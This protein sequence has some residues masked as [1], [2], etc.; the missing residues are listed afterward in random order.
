MFTDRSSRNGSAPRTEAYISAQVHLTKK[1]GAGNRWTYV[2]R[3]GAAVAAEKSVV[4]FPTFDVPRVDNLQLTIVTK[5]ENKKAHIALQAKAGGM[6]IENVLKNGKNAACKL[7][8]VNDYGKVVVAE[9]GDL[10]KF[11]FT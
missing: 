9:K 4:K 8:V 6:N 2:L 5:I 3:S 7:K 1:D 11:G 10:S